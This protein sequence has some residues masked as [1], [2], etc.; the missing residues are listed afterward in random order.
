MTAKKNRLELPRMLK[1]NLR[2]RQATP[3]DIEEIGALNR[4]LLADEAE[5]APLYE[6]WTRDLMSGHH[7]TT[8]A[9]DFIVVEDTIA[10]K[11]VSSAGLISQA[12][13]YEDISFPV[14]RPELIATDPAYRRQGL[15]RAIFEAIHTLSDSYGHRVQAITGIP[16]FYRQF[17][18]E[19]ALSLLPGRVLN[20][21]DIP[22]LEADKTEPYQV[23][24]VSEADI[25]LLMSMYNHDCNGKLVT[26]LI[27][28]ARWRYELS[29]RSAGL[30]QLIMAYF[31]EDNAGRVVGYYLTRARLFGPNLMVYTIFVNEG[32]S[33]WSVLPSVLRALKAQGE[34]YATEAEGS[35]M[36]L[37][38]ALGSAHPIYELLNAKLKP[39]QSLDSWYIRVA[40]LPGFIRHIAPVLEQRLSYSAMNGFSGELNLTFYRDGL[41]LV[42]DQGK[43][44]QVT[45]WQA[46]DTDEEGP[47]AGFPPLVFLQLLFGYHSLQELRDWFPDCWADEEAAFLLKALFPKK[48]SWIVVLS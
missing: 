29:G 14:G 47:G 37:Y 34:T 23:Q 12:W 21:Q 28:E 30:G 15:V 5:L 9:A 20:I 8:T 40:D 1:D 41:R 32:I 19:Y 10:K 3:A 31:I 45:Q 6:M 22:T 26:S 46:P 11:I 13:R 17:G 35:L 18:Y 7:P 42:L 38:L 39:L 2:V 4:Q 27:D 24:P 25:P 48:A 43:I 16:W 33:Y 36:G 44:S